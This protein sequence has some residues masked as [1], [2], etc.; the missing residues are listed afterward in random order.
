[1]KSE[2]KIHENHEHVH[3]SDCGHLGIKH[4]GHTDYAHDGHLHSPHDG[5]FDEHTLEVSEKNPAACTPQHSCGGH[6][7]SH[8]HGVGCGHEAIPHGDHTD[9]LV[10]D[11]LHHPHGEHCD[12]HG[13][14]ELAAGAR[15]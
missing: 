1:M 2:H 6:D 10:N 11:H 4:N 5:H 15:A 13:K 7:K 8:K 14:V 9:Y 3:G 12:N